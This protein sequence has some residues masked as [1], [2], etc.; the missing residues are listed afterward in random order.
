MLVNVCDLES[1]LE[2]ATLYWTLWSGDRDSFI[3]VPNVV[4]LPLGNGPIFGNFLQ[5]VKTL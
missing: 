4:R 1:V 5:Q 2:S 3:F